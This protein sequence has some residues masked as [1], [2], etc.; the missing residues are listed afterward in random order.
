MQKQEMKDIEFTKEGIDDVKKHLERFGFDPQN[1]T[2]IQR[3]EAIFRG[4]MQATYFDINFYTH[5]RREFLHYKALGYVTGEP[6]DPNDA[7]RLWNNTH[8][9]TLEEFGITDEV[10]YHPDT[11]KGISK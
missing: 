10:L 2:M 7:Y 3:L 5:E 9:A 11:L 4:E 1:A 8:T 6:D